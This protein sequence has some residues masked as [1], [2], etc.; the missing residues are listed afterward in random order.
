M[1]VKE[2]IAKAIYDKYIEGVESLEPSWDKLPQDHKDRMISAT[3]AGIKVYL[4]E[5]KKSGLLK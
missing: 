5:I 1:K 2:K 4:D 3:E